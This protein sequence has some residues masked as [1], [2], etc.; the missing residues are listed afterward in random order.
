SVGG[1]RKIHVFCE[2]RGEHTEFFANLIE[3]QP[4]ILAALMTAESKEM[5]RVQNALDSRQQ[6]PKG[7]FRLLPKSETGWRMEVTRQW[8]DAGGREGGSNPIQIGDYVRAGELCV[9]V[10]SSDTT[11]R[12]SAACVRVV[13]SLQRSN[14]ILTKDQ[15]SARVQAIFSKLSVK[16]VS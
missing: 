3:R 6:W 11:L 15:V 9:A 13:N 1:M 5:E 12:T 4:T 2:K 14:D 16:P 10:W 7:S 8:L